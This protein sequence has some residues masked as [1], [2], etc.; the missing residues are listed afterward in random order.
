MYD[1]KRTVSRQNL[2]PKCTP[3][4]ILLSLMLMT[5]ATQMVSAVSVPSTSGSDQ[6]VFDQILAPIWKVYNLVKYI[7][8]AVAALFIVFAGIMY[9]TA[10]NDLMKR[11]N[12]KHM[13]SYVVLGLI[14]IWAAPLIVQ[15]FTA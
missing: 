1:Q 5:I 12:A 13:I 14:V 10:G 11:E 6:Q 9:M 4:L 7:A 2:L 3:M 8:T 15:L